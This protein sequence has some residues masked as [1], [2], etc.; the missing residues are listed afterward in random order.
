M[1]SGPELA[2]SFSVLLTIARAPGQN[3]NVQAPPCGVP[4][5]LVNRRGMTVFKG[6]RIAEFFTDFDPG[7]RM[8]LKVRC[9]MEPNSRVDPAEFPAWSDT[10]ATRH[11]PPLRFQP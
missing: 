2:R 5:G 10:S 6:M 1:Q 11:G 9:R 8:C 3:S 7:F 4:V